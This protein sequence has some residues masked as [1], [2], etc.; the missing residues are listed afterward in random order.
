MPFTGSA[1]ILKY[2][3]VQTYFPL[4]AEELPDRDAT[5]DIKG[6]SYPLD[7]HRFEDSPSAY[8]STHAEAD[9]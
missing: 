1:E 9:V 2:H 4:P 6:P 3:C 5:R 7:V 8:E